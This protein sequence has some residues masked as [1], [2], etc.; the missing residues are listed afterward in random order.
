MSSL[1]CSN[2][3]TINNTSPGIDGYTYSALKF[4]WL[5][6]GPCIAQGFESMVEEGIFYPSL[7]TAS[8][9]LIPKKGDKKLL[10][11]WRPISL[12]SNITKVCTK[13]FCN[14]FK[15]VID[16]LTSNSQKVYSTKKVINKTLINT[17]QCTKLA[18]DETK[19]S[20][21]I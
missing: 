7:K 18:N 20:F 5:L 19:R 16:K 14:Q 2:K 12:I 10:N 8:I 6:V 17:L 13:A 15:K 9:K 4:L 1:R 11:N 21:L 3:Q